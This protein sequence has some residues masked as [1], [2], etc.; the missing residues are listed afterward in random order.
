[1]ARCHRR[2]FRAP[3]RCR[4]ETGAPAVR[5]A[6]RGV[7]GARFRAPARC[8]SETGAPAVRLAGRGV[9]GAGFA[10]PRDAGRR[11]ALQRRGAASSA[12]LAVRLAASVRCAR[13]R[14]MPVGDRRS[15]SQ[16]LCKCSPAREPQ[17]SGATRRQGN[18]DLRSAQP[19]EG[20]RREGP[21]VPRWSLL[22]RD[23]GVQR[24]PDGCVVH[25]ISLR[26]AQRCRPPPGELAR[27]RRSLPCVP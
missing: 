4:S 26:C 16:L 6:G 3:A 12:L 14:A 15:M 19:A 27:G 22:G 9:V 8:R 20:G 1:M 23:P 25:A 2:W 5:L 24:H 18:A 13:S 21:P 11:P 10:L 17:Q 7:I